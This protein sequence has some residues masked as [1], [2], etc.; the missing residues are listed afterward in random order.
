[1]DNNEVLKNTYAN[2]LE[3]R[4]GMLRGLTPV[5]ES[6]Y[7]R[8]LMVDSLINGVMRHLQDV[9]NHPERYVDRVRDS[10]HEYAVGI[11]GGVSERISGIAAALEKTSSRR[12]PIRSE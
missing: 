5:Q 2:L 12:R 6:E 1:M 9:A 7:I 8:E 10:F 4:G 3:S 11:A